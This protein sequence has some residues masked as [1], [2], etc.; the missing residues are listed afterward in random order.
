MVQ[1][2]DEA[3]KGAPDVAR[4]HAH[5]D[6][7][8]STALQQFDRRLKENFFVID[9]K[10]QEPATR[11]KLINWLRSDEF[12]MQIPAWNEEDTLPPILKFLADELGSPKKIT[13]M[14]ADSTD[15]TADVSRAVGVHVVTQSDM[16]KCVKRD[17][18]LDVLS[19][20]NPRG[21]GMTLYAFW[22][23][24]FLLQE[25]GLPKYTCT[26]DSDIKNYPEYDALP[27]V[28]YPIV[29]DGKPFTYTKIGKP[30]RNN[31]ATFAGRCAMRMVSDT[32][33]HYFNNL[34]RDMWMITGE[35]LVQVEHMKRLVHTTRSFVDTTTAMY[36]VDLEAAGAGPTA[37]VASNR[38]RIDKKN[39][40]LKEWTILYSIATNLVGY[41][42]LDRRVADLTLADIR[43]LN[44]QIFPGLNIFPYIPPTAEEPM[45]SV[46]IMNDRYIPSLQMM[47]DNGWIDWD[48][49]KAMKRKYGV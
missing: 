25:K 7:A 28:A 10:V 3:L 46:E 20:P 36:F 35:Y 29:I 5:F 13:V 24:R 31:E 39:D 32:G 33:M 9:E 34:S 41:A 4:S 12:A 15:K 8:K 26:C 14:N 6:M 1:H 2:H 30:G 48:Q 43:K 38:S 16:F 42:T 45:K 40:D 27:Y 44:T 49:V 18:L 22:I 11:K 19:D 21:R 17:A 23:Y 37:I 47:I